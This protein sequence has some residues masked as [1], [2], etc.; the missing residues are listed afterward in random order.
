MK[1]FVAVLFATVI[2]ASSSFAASMLAYNTEEYR[3]QGGLDFDSAA[4]TSFDIEAGYGYFVDDYIEL[5]GLVS[6][7][8]NDFTSSGSIGGFGEY[9]FETETAVIPFAGSQLRLIYSSFDIAGVDDDSTMALALGIYG[10][11]K[12]FIYDNL[13]V[14]ARMLVEAATDDVYAEEDD[15]SNIDFGIDFGLRVFF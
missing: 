1:R 11:V 2:T 6:Y 14:S 13:A 4:G 12:Y 10:G 3:L 15:V 8:N 5:G 9:N 7:L